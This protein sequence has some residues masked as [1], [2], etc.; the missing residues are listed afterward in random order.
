[1]Q[2][3]SHFPTRTIVFKERF[4]ERVFDASSE[5]LLS[6][7][8]LM[9]LR[10]RYSNPVWGYRPKTM[11]PSEEETEFLEFY[12]TEGKYLPR[13][14]RRHADRIFEQIE[15]RAVDVDDPDWN[16]YNNVEELLQLPEER[17]IGYRI[18]FRGKLIPTT[19]YLLLQRQ[20]HP[21]EGLSIVDDGM[22]R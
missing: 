11:T 4:Q 22:N 13:M 9:I 6:A 10:E 3:V 20:N 19:F 17:A 18:P 7:A 16:W 15:E 14:L 12:R 8:C 5:E 1:M 2:A 21:N